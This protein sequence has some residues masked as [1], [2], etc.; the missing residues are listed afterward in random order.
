MEA[1]FANEDYF[2]GTQEEDTMDLATLTTACYG[3]NFSSEVSSENLS[4]HKRT[5][6]NLVKSKHNR[7]KSSIHCIN[8]TVQNDNGFSKHR[9]HCLAKS[10]RQSSTSSSSIVSTD[11]SPI[12]EVQEAS[13]SRIVKVDNMNYFSKEELKYDW[14]RYL[15]QILQFLNGIV[16]MGEKGKSHSFTLS[17]THSFIH[18]FTLKPP[19]ILNRSNLIVLLHRLV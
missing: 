18:S 1:I 11:V 10:I 3:N 17:L 5:Q 16:D 2:E 14:D 7:T 9:R 15:S 8:T 6:S 19:V 4:L 12:D 13:S